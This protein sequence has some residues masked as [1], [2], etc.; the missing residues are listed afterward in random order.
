[1]V[2]FIRRLHPENTESAC[3]EETV[4]PRPRRA[5]WIW[6]GSGLLLV[7]TCGSAWIYHPH[8]AS[9]REAC[10]AGL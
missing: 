7:V 3:I 9:A 4:M 1:M 10:A 6:A 5:A 2:K 8:S